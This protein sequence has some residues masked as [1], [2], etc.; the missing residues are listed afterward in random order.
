MAALALLVLFCAHSSLAQVHNLALTPE[1]L[2]AKV[3]VLED[4]ANVLGKQLIQNQ[5]FVEERIRSDGMSGVKKVRLYR[6]GTSPYYADTHVAQSAIA[7]HDHANYDRTLGI[8][9]FIGVL[10]GVEFR[11]RH[12]DYK[13]KMPSTTSRTYHETE[14]ILFPSV[15]PE[16]LH[17]T[18]IQ[19]QIVEMREW[20]RAFKE[21]NTTIRD[22]R[23]YFRPL[24]CAL[25]GAWTL[26]KDIEESFPSDRHHLDATSWEDM[27]EKIS[28]T[29]YT[30]NKHN[31]EN[32]AFL[33]S[34]L[35]SMEGGYPQFAQWNYR[36]ICHPVSFDVPTSYFKLDDDL[37]HRLAND[38]TLKRAPFS[39]SA[40]FKV[41]EF[42]RERQTTY[43][44]LDRMMSELPGLDNYLANLTD[45]TYGL[46]ANDISQ[47]ENTLNAGYYH[48]WYHY[49]EMGAM[50]DSVNHR[51]FN[52]E[53]LWVAMTTQSHIMPLSTNYCVQDQ[54]VRDTRRV[55]FAVPLEV[56][57]ATP[58]LSWNPY[59]VAFYPADPKT[60]T[61]AQSVTANGRNG[62][63]TPG[64]AYNG[65]N[66]ENYY[67]TPVGFYASSDVE[68]DTADTAKGSVGVLDKQGI[69]RQMAASGPRIIT[70]DIQGVGTVRLRYP[71]FPVHS[72]GSTVG[73]ELV[74]LKEIVMKMTQYAHLLGE[75]QG[76][77]LPSNPDVHFILAE[78]YQNPPGLHSHDL[79]LTG[80]E[81]AAVLA[82][83]DTLVVTSL[84]LGHTHELKVHFDKTLSAYV[85]VTCDGMAS[86]WDGHARRLV[87]DE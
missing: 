59:N 10:N 71:I 1:Q 39:R 84:A 40:R 49:S 28:F 78:T 77:Y 22:Y 11:T 43:T 7:I 23:P 36:V 85:Y 41:N 79:V 44:T 50:G 48:R 9:E 47:A 80:A 16:V 62:G 52:D 34:K 53:N 25:E 87:L 29:S 82:G 30:G 58:I 27:A 54:C 6:E 18:T 21:Q 70:P 37:G 32:F 60:D 19:E 73:R 69:V 66:R 46:V 75:G 26:A 55:T 24:L 63:S 51:G 68:A 12:N 35:Y 83:N 3:K 33:P 74:A 64:T 57:Y 72:E 13:L 2:T 31:L 67:R 38:L 45:K 15:P 76:G 17:K 4:I 56:I 61:L 8:G 42:D 5:L 20:F 14:D 86:C 81:N 65:T